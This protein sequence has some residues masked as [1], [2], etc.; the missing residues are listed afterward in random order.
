MA[1]PIWS[2]TGTH[3]ANCN[4][5]LGCPCQFNGRP[6][7]GDCRA[8]VAWHIE[9]G[10]HGDIRL[11]GLTAVTTYAWPGAVHEGNGEMQS[12]IDERADEDQ[13]RALTAILQGED[14]EPGMTMLQIYRAMCTTVHPTLFR[15]IELH[16]ELESRKARLRIEGIVE[17]DVEPIVNPV[18]GAVH[19]AR[20]ELP[21]GKEFNS[22][23]VARGTTKSTGAVSLQF[24][25][26]HAHL[27]HNSMTSAG[28]APVA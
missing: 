12:I 22:A 5:D 7:H 8:V 2:I 18:T 15:P 3:F 16:A 26:S 27:V 6:S 13:R 24:T 1:D 23:E 19:R 20:I 9:R 11:D 21:M 28:I 14:A 10:H 4:C 25:N 17:T